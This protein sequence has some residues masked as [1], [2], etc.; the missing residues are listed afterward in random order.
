MFF[1]FSDALFSGFLQLKGNF[2]RGQTNSKYHDRAPLTLF[3][4]FRLIIISSH[5]IIFIILSVSCECYY[6][7][8]PSRRIRIFFNPQFFLSDTA[9]V[10]TH[11]ANSTANPDIFESDDVAKLCP[12]SYRTTNQYG[13]ITCRPEWIRI[14]SDAC[15]QVNLWTGKFLNL[16]RKSCGC[17]E[18]PD[19]CWRG[20]KVFGKEGSNSYQFSSSAA[21]PTTPW[22]P[23]VAHKV[24]GKLFFALFVSVLTPFCWV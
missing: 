13:G 3:L 16:E 7:W 4:Y 24:Q 1:F 18:Y 11:P 17:K 6:T 21:V 14:L 22:E 5:D 12:V 23:Y 10:H 20:L 8:T 9:S 19:T 2:V 15:G